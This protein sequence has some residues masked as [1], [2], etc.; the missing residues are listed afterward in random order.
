MT[1]VPHTPTV[2]PTGLPRGHGHKPSPKHNCRREGAY[3][4]PNNPVRVKSWF[5]DHIA[6]PGCEVGASFLAPWHKLSLGHWAMWYP[7]NWST[8]SSS[9]F[10]KWE[11][12]PMPFYGHHPWPIIS[13][14]GVSAKTAQQCLEPSHEELLNYPSDLCPGYGWGSLLVFKLCFLYRGCV[15]RVHE[16]LKVLFPPLPSQGQQF[17]SAE[18]SLSQDLLSLS[19]SSNGLPEPLWGLPKI[20]LH[21]LPN[22]LPHPGFCFGDHQRHSPSGLP[23]PICFFR[24]PLGQPSAIPIHNWLQIS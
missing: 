22:L 16:L 24:T 10:P 13:V 3:D 12:P 21:S 6:P 4:P 11:P 20:C 9:P 23:V 1:P 5:H 19:E 8:P 18:H 14:P 2:S 7:D 15:G 17:S